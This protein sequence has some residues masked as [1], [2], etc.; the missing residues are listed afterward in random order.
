M[1]NI[2]H[3][4]ACMLCVPFFSARCS[5]SVLVVFCLLRGRRPEPGRLLQTK[6]HRT[7][8]RGSVRRPPAPRRRPPVPNCRMH[9]LHLGGRRMGGSKYGHILFFLSAASLALPFFVLRP[10]VRQMGRCLSVLLRLLL[11]E[12]FLLLHH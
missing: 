8:Q 1:K 6:R 12:I 11:A 9:S 3:T 5:V 7:G 2:F 10:S 4:A